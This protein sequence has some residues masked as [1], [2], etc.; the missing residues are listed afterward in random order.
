ML[1]VTHPLSTSSI[2]LLTEYAHNHTQAPYPEH[3]TT[4]HRTSIKQHKQDDH[5]PSRLPLCK[6]THTHSNTEALTMPH[7]VADIVKTATPTWHQRTPDISTMLLTI[8]QLFHSY[9]RTHTHSRAA[10]MSLCSASITTPI[11][12]EHRV[13][14]HLGWMM[15]TLFCH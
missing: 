15:N 10:M 4:Q 6:H 2:L 7:R 11:I 1:F 9:N 8:Q 14:G 12:S 5:P 3:N 13:T